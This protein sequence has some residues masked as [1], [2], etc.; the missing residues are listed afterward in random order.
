MSRTFSKTNES[1]I[2]KRINSNGFKIHESFS[3]VER[4]TKSINYSAPNL[5]R[6]KIKETQSEIVWTGVTQTGLALRQMFSTFKNI[7]QLSTK[8]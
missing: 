3:Q 2:F 4:D 8:S 7:Y 1:Q 6:E 5:C